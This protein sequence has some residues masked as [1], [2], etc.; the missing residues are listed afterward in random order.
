MPSAIVHRLAFM[1]PLQPRRRAVATIG[2]L[3]V[4]AGVVLMGVLLL[5]PEPSFVFSSAAASRRGLLGGVAGLLASAVG[6]PR[7]KAA[8]EP[9]DE[10]CACCERDWCGCGEQC[11]DCHAYLATKGFKVPLDIAGAFDAAGK[12]GW[13]TALGWQAARM[14]RWKPVANEDVKVEGSTLE[15]AGQGLF[16]ATLLPKGA[17]L[18]PYQGPQL[19]FA[20]AERGGSYMWCPAKAREVIG[21]LKDSSVKR[22]SWLDGPSFCVDAQPLVKG[23]PSRYVNAAA[24]EKQCKAVNTE[25]CQIGGVMYYRTTQ[26]VA[27]GA[28]LVTD[29][30]STYW[31]GFDSCQLV[32]E[33]DLLGKLNSRISGL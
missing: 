14:P 3:L 15:G 29:Y 9:A 13:G 12:I 10:P 24:T 21:D 18:P 19:S 22:G 5:L 7:A 25:I 11:T 2:P 33:S 27:P 26:P 4:V 8:N 20:E 16:A 23:N 28:E 1:S 17:V 30:G 31:P 32:T 6:Q